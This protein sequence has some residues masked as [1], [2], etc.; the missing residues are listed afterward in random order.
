MIISIIKVVWFK[1]LA[2]W[3]EHR[4]SEMSYVFWKPKEPQWRN[5]TGYL[6]PK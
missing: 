4:I 3:M 2:I 1:I 5:G 6:Q